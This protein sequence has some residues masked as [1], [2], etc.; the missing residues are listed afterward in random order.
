[1]DVIGLTSGVSA[2][3]AGQGHT[4]ALTNGGGVKCWGEITPDS[5]GMELTWEKP[6][7]L[8]QSARQWHI[9]HTRIYT[10]NPGQIFAGNPIK[11]EIT[12]GADK[13]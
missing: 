12:K 3:A 6:L 2:I 9:Y 4:C 11:I 5:W 1:V 7:L 13:R 10:E 8:F